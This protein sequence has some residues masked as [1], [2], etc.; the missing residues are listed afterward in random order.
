[1]K[2][3]RRDRKANV[4]QWENEVRILEKTNTL[5]HDHIVRFVTAFRYGEEPNLKHC[6]C[7][8]WASGGN[9]TDLW[10]GD[11]QPRLSTSLIRAVVQQ[12]LGLAQA[13]NAIHYFQG[14]TDEQESFIHG[15]IK[16]SNILWFRDG[17]PIGTLKL[18]DWGQAK[19]YSHYDSDSAD[20]T[21]IRHNTATRNNTT[22]NLGTR[23]YEPPEVETGLSIN[24]DG[25]TKNVRSRLYDTW[26]FGCFSLEFIIW[27]LHGIKGLDSF[28]GDKVGDYG[29]SDSF[30]EINH[31]K[32]AKVHAV[33]EHWMDHLGKDAICRSE[34]SALGDLLDIV[35]YGLLVVK[36]PQGGGSVNT[37]IRTLSRFVTHETKKTSG[38]AANSHLEVSDTFPSDR[39]NLDNTD[40]RSSG[41]IDMPKRVVNTSLV[42]Q[43]SS[44][45][46]TKSTERFRAV[47]LVS[48]LE[49]VA[50]AE[51]SDCYWYQDLPRSP[52]P[53]SFRQRSA[54]LSHKIPLDMRGNYENPHFDPEEWLVGLDND[55]AAKTFETLANAKRL[56]HERP[57]TVTEH[58][59]E[60]CRDFQK[61]LWS[62]F[63]K[64]TYST[65][66]LSR[67][68]ELQSCD[69]CVLLWQVC[70]NTA[71]DKHGSVRFERRGS[72]IRL[73]HRRYPVLSL[74]QDYG[75]SALERVRLA[76]NSTFRSPQCSH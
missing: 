69:L 25:S 30:Y 72:T 54:E 60:K 67:N 56:S 55:F 3:F 35:R 73:S 38:K 57:S 75:T 21:R 22:G 34:T 53:P 9:L 45:E 27:L 8:E 29:L 40:F 65:Q 58:L 7:F 49:R 4:R 61:D 63:L 14:S 5:R 74:F 66:L 62:P 64:I 48:N 20:I 39:E 24:E 6:I 76:S 52:I 19:V 31:A 2:E 32:L 28:R 16:P 12:L 68:A 50:Q 15:D 44:N 13:L 18:A 36:L 51:E 33:V 26:S 46:D 11:L 41:I 23:R 47:E 1:V 10:Y 17:G 59:C 71:S 42:G 70:L 43:E 37:R